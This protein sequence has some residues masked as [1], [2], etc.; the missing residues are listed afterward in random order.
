M[1][2]KGENIFK[3]KD[4]RWEGRYIKGR[5]NGKAVYGYV[6]AKSYSEAKKKKAEAIAGLLPPTR[7]E[8]RRGRSIPE[9]PIMKDIAYQWL[10]ELKT[11][12]RKSTVVKYEGQLR[13]HIIPEFGTK[14]I[15]EISN[16]DLISFSRKL[17][18]KTGRNNKHLSP[19]TAADIISRM[20][21]IRKFSVLRGYQVNYVSDCTEI[22]QRAE[23]IRVLSSEEEKKLLEYLKLHHNPTSLGILLSLCTGIRLGELCA[24]KWSDFSLEEREFHVSKTMQR[25]P[26]PNKFALKK[27]AVEIGEPKSQSSV[28]T[29][30]LPEKLVSLLHSAYCND[31]YVLSGYKHYFIEPRTMENRFKAVL[32]KCGIKDTNFHTLRH[33]FATRCVEVGFDVKTLS[34][35]LGHASVSITLNR[36]VHPSMRTKHEN[37]NRLNELF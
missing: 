12:R 22:P 19:R 33:T 4:G 11:T 16:N 32:K 27:T 5:E 23:R 3:R 29:I 37:M 9:Q 31:A 7:Q 20:R 28:R 13:N 2:R 24:L 21:S 10:D 18:L 6:F 25:L 17:L 1:P 8:V 26:N 35:I 34:E 30:P 14:R 15:D 36:Y